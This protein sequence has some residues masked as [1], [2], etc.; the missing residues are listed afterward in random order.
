MAAFKDA[1]LVEAI[2]YEFKLAD[3]TRGLNRAR[4][5][6]LFNG[7]PPYDSEEAA[8]NNI[9]V[10][11]NSLEGT[12][13]AHDARSQFYSA[14]LKP[15]VYFHC[16]TDMAA[17]HRR[18]EYSSIVTA[19][20]N[21][22]MKRSLPYFE[23][24]R[25]KFALD[26]LHGVGP[27]AWEN[28]YSWCPDP[29]GI[30]DILI[31]GKTLLTMKNLPFFAI[32]R[33]FTAPEL[34]KLTRRENLD[35]GWNVPLADECIKWVDKE[36]MALL[37]STW[38]EV[39]SPEKLEERVKGDGGFYPADTVPT[40]D[41]F[42]FYFWTDD[43][44][45]AGWRRRIILD[46]WGTP[47]SV[48]GVTSMSRRTG[49]IYRNKSGFLYDSG[50]R[51]YADKREHMVA[52]QF[53][54][55]SAVAP[56][57]YHSVRSLGFLLYSVCHLQNRMRCKFSEAVFEAL[58][59]YFKISN[60][61]EA[62]RALKLQL[63]NRGFIDDTLKPLTA[64]ER[65]QVNS[66]L[67]ELGLAENRNLIESHSGSYTQ[68]KNVS[69]NVEKT[70]YQVMAEVN[71]M[72]AMISAALTQAY[73]YQDG[74]DRE[75]LRRC[76]ICNSKD[77]DVNSFQAGCLKRGVP[78]KLL[79]VEAWET[80]HERVFGSGNQTLE[81]AIADWLMQNREKYD[82]DSQREIL[83]RATFA[84]TGDPGLT[85]TLVPETA[86]LSDSIHDAQL[87]AAGLLMGISMALKQSVN[88]QEYCEAL[89]ATMAE[90]C[91]KI[92]QRGDVATPEELAGLQNLAGQT[93]QG[94]PI[95]GNGIADHISVL[96]QNKD[97]KS[98]VKQ[99]GDQ[100]GKLMNLVKAFAQRLAEQ[101]KAQA[102]QNG[103]GADPKKMLEVQTEAMK[104]KIKLDNMRESHAQRTAQRQI[105][106]EMEQKR[107]AE[108]HS[109]E[110]QALDLKTAGDINRRHLSSL[111]EGDE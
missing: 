32:Y 45:K 46:S 97:A 35:P 14:F 68:N 93:I 17:K 82:P 57:Q 77:P 27:S 28:E 31:P 22:M 56:F 29:I 86:V 99:L 44:D 75:I 104:A 53:A 25:S 49:E 78:E 39:W 101:Q 103:N 4:I 12:R 108:R 83:R 100:L 19:E 102:K 8:E 9:V 34:I 105:D 70:R 95:K 41:T 18:G 50:D 40:V 7:N 107:Q 69:N 11:V 16:K 84:I 109:L 61:D 59:M 110:V 65:Y 92:S 76:M 71:S 36:S 74:E 48:G 72:T 52:F 38:P 55:L 54:D 30:E 96:A 79:C 2:C 89:L 42:D 20:I 13:L 73:Q 23:C 3:Y 106:F 10:N 33:S 64:Q 43:G 5:N 37:G 87:A 91:Q 47:Q 6:K 98:L 24:Y 81:G 62:Q 80:E 51:V 88:H 85:D 90:Q 63:V 21:K 1:Q 15:G 60:Q 26:V 58:M 67:V 66:A 94:Q 111:S